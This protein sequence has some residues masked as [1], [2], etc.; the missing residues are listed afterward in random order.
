MWDFFVEMGRGKGKGG[1]VVG[2]EK[3]F[4]IFVVIVS[5]MEGFL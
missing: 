4:R 5:K 2:V 3:V 1:V